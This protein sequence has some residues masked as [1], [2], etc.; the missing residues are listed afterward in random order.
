MDGNVP[1]TITITDALPP[2]G[3]LAASAWT[4]CF[5]A[6]HYFWQFGLQTCLCPALHGH[7]P[8]RT[9]ASAAQP[10]ARPACRTAQPMDGSSSP[11]KICLRRVNNGRGMC[12]RSF[13][14]T[15]VACNGCVYPH[16]M[17]FLNAPS[18]WRVLPER[19]SCSRASRRF[20]VGTSSGPTYIA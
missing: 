9:R 17:E 11:N 19:R 18:F 14:T 4:L 16:S 2:Y 1:P 8:N 7:Q 12:M 6:Q 10:L 20:K 5:L 13:S 15:G 3:N